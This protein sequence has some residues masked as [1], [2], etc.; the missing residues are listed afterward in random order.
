MPPD[1]RDARKRIEE[2]RAALTVGFR[3]GLQSK[4]DRI[5]D[6]TLEH[7]TAIE[8][9]VPLVNALQ[10]FTRSRWLKMNVVER[11]NSA[12]AEL[13]QFDLYP[14]ELGLAYAEA[15]GAADLLKLH[16]G[17]QRIVIDGSYACFRLDWLA[18]DLQR[19][20]GTDEMRDHV[21]TIISVANDLREY[22]LAE[23]IE[24]SIRAR[25]SLAAFPRTALFDRFKGH[26]IDATKAILVP[27][28]QP[29]EAT[30]TVSAGQIVLG[31]AAVDQHA[32]SPGPRARRGKREA[33]VQARGDL[34][35][36]PTATAREVAGG[37]GCS[38]GLVPQLPAWK[39]VQEQR[40]KGRKPKSSRTVRLTTKLEKAVGT[41]DEPLAKLIAEQQADAEPSP[42]EGDSPPLRDEGSPRKARLYLR[43]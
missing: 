21:R 18:D 8:R 2:C 40:A 12:T 37:I 38:L 41:E 9:V 11:I 22:D 10:K 7:E 19:G 31:N 26:L 16:K 23:R 24:G 29:D 35:E 39:A 32:K 3:R 1:P 36:H 20:G 13:D 15:K 43:P 17:E 28:P 27:R 5:H 33:N 42:L 34:K 14:A 25:A 4:E 30:Q 6:W